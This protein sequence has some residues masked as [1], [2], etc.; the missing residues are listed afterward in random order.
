MNLKTQNAMKK[1]NKKII[2]KVQKRNKMKLNW[3]K[4]EIVFYCLILP[5]FLYFYEFEFY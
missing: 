5:F 2:F 3:I 1:K 4:I